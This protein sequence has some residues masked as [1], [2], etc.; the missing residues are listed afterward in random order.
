M[1][2]PCEVAVKTVSPSIRALLTKTL[3]EKHKMTETQ[4]ANI[5]GITQSAVSKYMKNA[6]GITIPLENEVEIQVITNQ[7]V[8]LLMANPRNQTEIMKLFCQAC[9]VIRNKGLMCT[10]C[11]Q[12]QKIPIDN[13][14]FCQSFDSKTY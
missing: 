8:D 14:D 4:A 10:L 13:C 2:T 1:I 12:N 5:L 3:L 11:Q 9:A 7:I 6:R